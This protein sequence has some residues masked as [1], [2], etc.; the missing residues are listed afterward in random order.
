M[1]LTTIT[2]TLAVLVTAALLAVPGSAQAAPTTDSA[3]GQG[4]LD[5]GARHFAFSAKRNTDGTVSG[6]ANLRNTSF[7]GDDGK[8]YYAHIDISCMNRVG[9]TVVMGGMVTKT[10]DAN[11]VDAVFFTV[12]D[13]GE[14]GKGVDK[15]S[16]AFFWDD[17]P[18]TTGDPQACLLTGVNDFPLEPIEKGNIQVK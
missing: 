11:L 3:N 8:A 15:I 4:I 17:D 10:N 6:H 18:T 14:P 9:N 1:H 12:Q 16:R 5:S 7:N 2:R 13:N